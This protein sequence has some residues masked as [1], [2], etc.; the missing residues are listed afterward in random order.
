MS[1]PVD[2][3]TALGLAR[4]CTPLQI[5]DAFRLLA[6]RHHPDLNQSDVEAKARLQELNAAYE[7]LSDPTK[8]RAYDRDLD[9]AS[10]ATAPGR[11][12]R[13]ENNLTQEVRLR[14]EDFLRGT[15]LDVRVKDPANPGETENY[16]VE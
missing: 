5:R 7:V 8:R 4:K 15:S 3:Y 9:R 11:G 10:R 12:A 16:R 13:I 6:K 14:M 1:S 2:H